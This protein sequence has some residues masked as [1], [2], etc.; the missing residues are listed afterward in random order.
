MLTDMWACGRIAIQLQFICWFIYGKSVLVPG[1]SNK[2]IF[3]AG[4]KLKGD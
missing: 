2:S 4:E 3:N 1:D